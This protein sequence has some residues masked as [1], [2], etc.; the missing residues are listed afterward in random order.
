MLTFD[1]VLEHFQGYR[2]TGA[3]HAIGIAVLQ[4]AAITTIHRV[5]VAVTR[6]HDIVSHAEHSL[7]VLCPAQ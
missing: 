4:Q 2:L 6:L 3:L 1:N 7:H 5:L